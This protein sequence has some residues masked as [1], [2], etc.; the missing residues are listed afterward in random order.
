MR[1]AV[2]GATRLLLVALMA[3]SVINVLWQ[4][5]SRYVTESPGSFTD[6]LARYLLVWVGLLGSAYA[7]G[8]RLHV[9]MDL[10]PQRAGKA[11]TAITLFANGIVA[12]F[13]LCVLVAGGAGLVHLAFELDQRSAAL[14]LPI[15]G[16]YLAAPLS[17]LLIAFYALDDMATAWRQRSRPEETS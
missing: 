5:F 12:V 14:G 2:D 17:G 3:A 6:E 4:V 16:V 10:L 8:Q 9:A 1:R 15:A 13:S 7:A 11:R